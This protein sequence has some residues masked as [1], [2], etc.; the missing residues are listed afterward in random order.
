MLMLLLKKFSKDCSL[1]SS[2][3]LSLFYTRFI[4]SVVSFCIAA[5]F[6]NMT[7]K[8]KDRLGL[9]VK[10]ASTIS[11]HWQDGPLAIYSKNMLMTTHYI[12]NSFKHLI[13]SEFDLLPSGY[14]FIKP[15]RKTKRFPLVGR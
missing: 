13:P 15:L 10:T 3:M 9:L 5:W 11:G 12:I 14:N 4:E 8:N 1:S 7:V 2:E 6:C